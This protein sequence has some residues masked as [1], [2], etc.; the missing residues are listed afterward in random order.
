[1]LSQRLLCR[2]TS[3]AAG[4]PQSAPRP[5]RTSFRERS[6]HAHE[7]PSDPVSAAF[8]RHLPP[9]HRPRSYPIPPASP[10]F[11]RCSHPLPGN[12]RFRT[13]SASAEPAQ[14]TLPHPCLHALDRSVEPRVGMAPLSNAQK[15][16]VTQQFMQL[17][18]APDR[19]AQ[20]VRHDFSGNASL[21]PPRGPFLTC[22]AAPNRSRIPRLVSWGPPLCCN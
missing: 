14:R 12:R 5:G 4:A 7:P 21:P 6:P 11:P 9:H 15:S 3:P 10:V 18:G 13:L 2:L 20:R 16:A 19:V 8:L 17:T 1:M 22:A